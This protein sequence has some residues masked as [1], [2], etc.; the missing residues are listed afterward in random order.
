MFNDF[1]HCQ[2]SSDPLR[3]ILLANPANTCML[4]NKMIIIYHTHVAIHCNTARQ[5][6]LNCGMYVYI[7][8]NDTHISLT[9]RV[10]V[11]NTFV[12][13]VHKFNET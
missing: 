10:Q 9:H 5:H 2:V 4:C 7:N 13:E 1:K 12:E 6:T 11:F 8:D 3:S